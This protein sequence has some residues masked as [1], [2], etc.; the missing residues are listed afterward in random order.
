MK[1]LRF[2]TFFTWWMQFSSVENAIHRGENV[3]KK[4]YHYNAFLS[5]ANYQIYGL[6][7]ALKLQIKKPEKRNYLFS[8]FYY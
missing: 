5:K 8:G 1:I 2:K 3:L 4:F 6:S 7:F